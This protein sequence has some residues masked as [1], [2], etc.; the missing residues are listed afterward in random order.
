MAVSGTDD[1][2][3]FLDTGS[4]SLPAQRPS[5]QVD[6]HLVIASQVPESDTG[7]KTAVP[8]RPPARSTTQ[9]R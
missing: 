7:T 4:G 5:S 6:A 3:A 2:G 8:A 9:R 1:M